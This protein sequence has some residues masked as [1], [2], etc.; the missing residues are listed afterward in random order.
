VSSG[1]CDEEWYQRGMREHVRKTLTGNEE[2][3]EWAQIMVSV[4]K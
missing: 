2:I 3:D 4:G 1:T